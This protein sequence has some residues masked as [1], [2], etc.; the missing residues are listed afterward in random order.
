MGNKTEQKSAH[1]N[2]MYHH[3]LQGM[4]D[5]FAFVDMEGNIV[6]SNK[7]FQDMLGYS[8]DELSRLTYKDITPEKWH[9]AESKIIREQII[10]RGYSDVYEKEYRKKD[11][12]IFPVELRTFLSKNDDNENEGMWAIVRDI[13]ERKRAEETLHLSELRYRT[14][15]DSINDAIHV[16]D[17][18]LRI[19]LINQTFQ[20]WIIKLGLKNFEI[21]QSIFELFPF[22]SEKIRQQ[23]QQVFETGEILITEDINQIGDQQISTE[24]RKIPII[25]ANKVTRV[26]TIVRDITERKLAEINLRDTKS[27]LNAIVDNTPFVMLLVTGDRKIRKV[28]NAALKFIESTENEIINSRVGSSLRCLNSFDT[29]E[30]CGFGPSCQTCPTRLSVLDTFQNGVNHRDVQTDLVFDNNGKPEKISLNISTSLVNVSQER[31]VLVCIEDITEKKRTHEIIAQQF[32][33]LHGIIESGSSPIFSIDKNYCYTSFNQAHKNIMKILYGADIEIGKSLLEYQTVDE[34]RIAAKANIDLA[35]KGE[36]FTREAFSGD[37]ELTRLYFEVNHNPIKDSDGNIVGVAVIVN[38]IT[39]RKQSESIIN[40]Q[41]S[42]LK[43]LLDVSKNITSHLELN[44][45]LQE[46]VQ[47]AAKYFSLDSGAIYLI[48]GENLYLG[49]TTP[50]LPSDFPEAYRSANIADHPHILK[51][52][53]TGKPVILY[54]TKTETLTPAEKSIVDARN[55]RSVL[56][57]PLEGKGNNIGVL[58]LGT[59]GVKRDFV[60]LEIELY[61]GIARYAS[62]AILNAELHKKLEVELFEKKQTEIALINNEKRLQTIIETEPECVKIVAPDGELLDMN[63]AGIKMLEASSLES[64]QKHKL[65]NF[66]LPEYRPAFINL[67]KRVISG[68]SGILEFEVEGLNGTRRWLETHAAPILDSQGKPISL[69]GVTRDITE[70]K[71]A[72]KALLISEEKMRSIF[73]VAPTGI[74]V[75][76]NRILMEINPQVCAMTG[77]SREELIGKNARILYPNE[78]EY[79]FVGKIKYEQIAEKG[80]GIVETRWSK[81]DGTIINIILASTPIIADDL[82]KGVIFTALDI[83]ERKLVDQTLM[84]LRSAVETSGEV[85]IMTD[86]DGIITYINPEFTRL[87]GYQKNE[88]IGKVTPRILKSGTMDSSAYQSFWQTILAKQTV[89]GE[90]VNRTKDGQLIYIEGTTNPILDEHGNLSGFLAIQ[91]NISERKHAENA[92]HESEK[93]FKDIVEWAPLGIYQSTPAGQFL[94]ANLSLASMLGYPSVEELM[95]INIKDCYYNSDERENIINKYTHSESGEIT[96]LEILWKKKNGSPISILLSA[97]ALKD[98]EGKIIYYEGFVHD[99]TEKKSLEAQ[100]LRTQRMESLGTLAG[101]IAHDLNNVL[102]PIL[103]AIDILKANSKDEKSQKVLSTLELNAIRGRDIIKQVLTFARGS[104]VGTHSPIHIKHLIKET[105][106]MVHETFPKNIQV[107][108]DIPKDLWLLSAD[109]TQLN[110]V[111]M[112]LCVNARDAMPKGGMLEISVNN[113]VAD[114][115]FVQMELQAHEG[116]YIILT[117]RDSGEGIPI[118]IIDKVFDPFFTTKEIGK[119]TGLGLSTTHTIVK[120]HGGFI[121]IKSEMGKGTIFNI[122]LPA[123]KEAPVEIPRQNHLVRPQGNGEGIL[124]VDDEVSVLDVLKETLELYNYRVYIAKDGIEGMAVYAQNKNYI[125]LAILDLVMPVMNGAELFQAL[126]KFNSNLPII[127]MSGDRMYPSEFS[128]NLVGVNA[129]IQKPFTSELLLTSLRKVLDK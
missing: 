75:V 49:A 95:K 92:L 126:R 69:L 104:K 53:I 117:V 122:Y 16:V 10:L 129:H 86:R 54:D 59:V 90:L 97:H 45:V 74:G 35:L 78:E 66:I 56:Y 99:I 61:N 38:D 1:K 98:S 3:L 25:E 113:F 72:E 64:V 48:K 73:R 84:Q 37:I 36:S 29:P 7:S 40:K 50:P 44:L 96:N 103:L 14:T 63:R 123:I 20:K 26:I 120:D 93:K 115:Q 106:S 57:I 121:N 13:T 39:Q 102:S 43:A 119:G 2:G 91:R 19:I 9:L 11:G 101:G 65:I 47:S 87:Y 5:G 100:F 34:D 70:R 89:K 58:I 4:M 124:I 32:A 41:N 107:S 88:V 6:E 114:K 85:I 109:A 51:S 46:I 30:G 62:Q 27:E 60:D 67:H 71:N 18:N 22:L 127:T 76:S 79:E 31:M 118:N 77:Y 111:L 28:N 55:L 83:T 82:S 110:Q 105:V 8:G 80:S 81:K 42:Y 15:I 33:T 94:T 21:G 52:F 24:T 125:D 128:S 112:N 108:S 17:D 116:T 68:E 23:Y 12:T